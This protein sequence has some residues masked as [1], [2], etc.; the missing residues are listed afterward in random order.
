MATQNIKYVKVRKIFFFQ[1]IG[2]THGHGKK[3]NILGFL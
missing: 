2:V 3:K 1:I